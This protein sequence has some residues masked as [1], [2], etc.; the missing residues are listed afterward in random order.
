MNDERDRD[1][2]PRD[3]WLEKSRQEESIDLSRPLG[4]QMEDKDKTNDLE[5]WKED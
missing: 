3:E 1:E 2:R 5:K 4:Q